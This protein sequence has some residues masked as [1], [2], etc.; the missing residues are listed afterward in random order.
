MDAIINWLWGLSGVVVY[1]VVAALV[2]AEDALFVGF[3]LP[4]ETAVVLGGVLAAQ[5]R[6]SV[7]WLGVAVT[8][9]AVAGD[10][11]GYAVGRR[12]GPKILDVRPLRRRRDRVEQAQAFIRR[13]GPQGVLL[14]RFTAFLRAMTPTLAGASHMEYR[15][16][17]LFNVLGGV[18]WGVGY[19]LVG[20]FAGTAYQRVESAAGGVVAAVLA[21]IVV[22]ALVVWQV[23]RRRRGAVDCKDPR[24]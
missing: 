24:R 12:L 19:T 7:Y 16:F 20:Y 1:L 18:L 3:V 21:V 4:G 13:W 15:R 14:G 23:R 5:G 9:A 17:L 8:L 10:S 22:T 2:F 6:L 11:V